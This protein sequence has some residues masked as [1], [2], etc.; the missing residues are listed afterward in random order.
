MTLPAATR[1]W[2]PWLSWFSADL[3]ATLGDILTRL[4][5]LLGRFHGRAQSGDA[6]PEG[7]EDLRRRGTYDR[8]LSSEW[9]L[10]DEL[11]DEFMRRA[12]GGEH[13]FVAPR[14][15]ARR[16]QRLIVGLFDAG[17]LQFGAPRLVHVALW[18]LLARR[19][20]QAGGTFRWGVA[21]VPGVLH[22]AAAPDDLLRL[23]GARSHALAGQAQSDSWR[24]WLAHHVGEGLGECWR[25]GRV[26]DVAA[27]ATHAVALARGF[28]G[29]VLDVRLR[30]PG[31]MR[32]ALL[33][34]VGKDA[35]AASLLQGRFEHRPAVGALVRS[36]AL[37]LR[38]APLLSEAGD[39]VAVPTLAKPGITVFR[40]PKPGTKKTAKAFLHL[41]WT[42]RAEPL[43]GAFQGK[44]LGI[45]LSG[46]QSR[47]H[48]WQLHGT[49]MNRPPKEEFDAPPGVSR[50]LPCA[51]LRMDKTQRVYVLD[52]AR[53]LVYWVLSGAG[54]GPL[55]LQRDVCAM[56]QVTSHRIVYVAEEDGLLWARSANGMR[57]EP[58]RMSLGLDAGRQPVVLIGAARGWR[59]GVG[60]GACAVGRVC[61]DGALEWTVIEASSARVE[62][63]RWS[64][65]MPA[66]A[67]IGLVPTEDDASALVAIDPSRRRLKLVRARG[68]TVVFNAPATIERHAV[69]PNSGIVAMLTSERHLIVFSTIDKEV[70]LTVQ[71]EN[72][73][74]S[75]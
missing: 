72:D 22:D 61:M 38:M 59:R 17:P 35:A 14:P 25:I 6:E 27:P 43:A 60:I 67:V 70:R 1:A 41:P 50:W 64:V 30:H 34:L 69:C 3:A 55:L 20:A 71:S 63:A 13:L 49:A 29:D 21:H 24:L 28:P 48:F 7:L 10:A 47:L 74:P 16:S 11:P 56:A 66:A 45:L 68:A 39:H 18:I 53:R 46:M 37:S 54:R 12:A 57:Q 36:D 75:T 9:L 15:R 40:V 52:A 31:G 26:A 73:V 5:P 2:L 58:M 62:P 32:H 44:H 4:D 33:P 42:A 8:L 51:A 65:S 19:A 23:L